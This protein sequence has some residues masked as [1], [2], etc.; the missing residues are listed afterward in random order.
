MPV[1]AKVHFTDKEYRR[2]H[3]LAERSG[4]GVS[5]YIREVLGLPP[6]KPKRE[7]DQAPWMHRAVQR[8]FTPEELQERANSCGLTLR[9]TCEAVCAS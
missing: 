4:V 9:E 7:P 6:M 8:G 1:K 2:L 5:G 3:R